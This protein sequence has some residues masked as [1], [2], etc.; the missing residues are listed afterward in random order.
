[1]DT[2]I[3]SPFPPPSAVSD[4]GAEKFLSDLPSRGFFS[5]SSPTIPSSTLGGM[6]VYICDHDTSPPE[7][8]LIKTDQMNILIR[9][10]L[11]KKQNHRAD[12]AKSK[13]VQGE[14][15]G[16]GACRK[17]AAEKLVALGKRAAT[18]D[19]EAETLRMSGDSL[20]GLTV[21]R[22]RMVLREKGLSVKGKKDE[23][24]ARLRTAN[25]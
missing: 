11:L 10:L 22:L 9:S 4:G 25:G 18:G 8:Q 14:S 3:P 24:I 15:S 2:K 6:R 17:R 20:Q 7:N 5:S 19:G 12:N 21:E 13:V 23:L 16:G 1:M